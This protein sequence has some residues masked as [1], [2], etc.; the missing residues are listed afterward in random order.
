MLRLA[1]PRC[2]F[3]EITEQM[4]RDRAL[5][6]ECRRLGRI[7]RKVTRLRGREW[8]GDGEGEGKRVPGHA[9]AAMT[10]AAERPARQMTGPQRARRGV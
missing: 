5:G 10:G 4:K 1:L 6:G 2:L 3:N 9:A 8:G 7:G